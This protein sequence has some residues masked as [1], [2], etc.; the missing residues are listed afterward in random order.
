MTNPLLLFFLL[1]LLFPY[2][3]FLILHLTILM[4]FLPASLRSSLFSYLFPF[5]L[6]FFS[7]SRVL[8]VLLNEEKTLSET[9]IH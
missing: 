4:F 8:A 9:E 5:V 2:Y 7:T 1:Y 6:S 3:I